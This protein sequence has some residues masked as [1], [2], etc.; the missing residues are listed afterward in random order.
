MKEIY[1]KTQKKRKVWFI[2]NC[3]LFVKN[4]LKVI[5]I[6]NFGHANVVGFRFYMCV[7]NITSQAVSSWAL[8]FIGSHGTSRYKYLR[9]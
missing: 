6:F 9:F 2:C 3:S 4:V 8:N 7:Y 5:Q 1:K